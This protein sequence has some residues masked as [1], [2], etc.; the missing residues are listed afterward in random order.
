MLRP[1][2]CHGRTHGIAHASAHDSANICTY[3]HSN[4]TADAQ[5]NS[6]AD[7]CAAFD[8]AVDHD[9][10]TSIPDHACAN[11]IPNQCSS[12]HCPAGGVERGH[13]CTHPSTICTHCGSER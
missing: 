7:H 12:A 9:A 6:S 11:S 3:G 13:R 2:L 10:G 1:D 4:C 5:T 8:T